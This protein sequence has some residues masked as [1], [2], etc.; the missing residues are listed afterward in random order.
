[1][2]LSFN[3]SNVHKGSETCKVSHNYSILELY[4]EVF[5]V[6]VILAVPLLNNMN[7]SHLF[8]YKSL[9]F[10]SCSVSVYITLCAAFVCQIFSRF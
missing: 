2:L 8:L 9:F 7:Q 5:T 4:H 1:M 6:F 10:Y 3:V